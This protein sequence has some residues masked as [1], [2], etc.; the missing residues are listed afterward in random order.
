MAVRAHDIALGSLGEDLLHPGS[1]N[2]PSNT[3]PL[4]APFAMVEIHR[5]GR[6]PSATVGARHLPEG[7]EHLSVLGPATSPLFEAI[8]RLS[9]L[10]G[11]K[12][13][14]VLSSR[15]D[16]MTDR[17]DNVA[18]RNLGEE[19]GVRAAERCRARQTE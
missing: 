10:P 3:D 6:K 7:V 5:A 18:L 16:S 15:P 8:R 13:L 17:A 11:S 9:G 2:H 1:P 12:P 4:V 14:L 19:A